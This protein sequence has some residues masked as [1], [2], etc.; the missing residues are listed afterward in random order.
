MLLVECM[1][2]TLDRHLYRMGAS[3]PAGTGSALPSVNEMVAAGRRLLVSGS[4]DAFNDVGRAALSL[5]TE[6][7]TYWANKSTAQGGKGDVLQNLAMT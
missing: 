6:V 4:G 2:S 5:G 1:R 3:P 7:Q